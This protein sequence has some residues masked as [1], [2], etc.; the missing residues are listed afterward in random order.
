MPTVTIT[1]TGETFPADAG[2]TILAAAQRAGIAFP[3][4]CQA[5][6]CGS[7]KCEWVDGDT[8]PLE[9]SE[10]ALTAAEMANQLILAC[11]T[12]VW[13]DTTIRRLADEE[14]VMHPSRNL[15]CRVSAIETSTHDVRTIRLAVE[16]TAPWIFSAGQYATV[17]FGPGLAKHY[18]MANTPDETTLEFQIR[19]AANGRTSV[20]AVDR[21]AVGD[22][23]IV[24][25]PHGTSY[26][27]DQHVGPIVLIGGG[28][29]LAPLQSILRTLLARGFASPIKLYFGVRAERDVYNEKL[30]ATLVK[31][32]PNF[33]YEIVL[34]DEPGTQR[35]TGFVHL[36]AA[37]DLTS[38]DGYKAYLAGPPVMVEAA[39][40]ILKEKG[41]TMRDIHADAYYDQP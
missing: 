10:Y 15:R 19:R 33:S 17:S 14:I 18:S 12:Q 25:G 26:L 13:G 30:F 24:S 28:T 1:D 11:R 32:H 22:A 40:A 27:R 4:S 8:M 16:D 7:C 6:N 21:L 36:A 23:V 5:G 35:R 38:V 39:T 20:H 2:E 3:H 34:S 41:L 9:H 37:A 29:G 31:Q